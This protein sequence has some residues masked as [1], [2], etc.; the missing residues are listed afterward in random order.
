MPLLSRADTPNRT[1]ASLDSAICTAIIFPAFL[2]QCKLYVENPELLAIPIAT[3][4]TSLLYEGYRVGK[5]L[6]NR[7]IKNKVRSVRK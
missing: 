2:G 3:N 7:T 4:V 6:L 1:D 5:Y